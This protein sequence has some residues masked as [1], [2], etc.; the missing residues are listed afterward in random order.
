LADARDVAVVLWLG[1]FQVGLAYVLLTRGVESV[2]AFEATT[3]LLLEPA[4]NPVWTWL[5][6]G[7]APARQSLAGGSI[8]VFATLANAWW[9]RREAAS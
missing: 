8:I 2:R 6:H 4:L 5:V 3:L 9:H 1:V 7:E